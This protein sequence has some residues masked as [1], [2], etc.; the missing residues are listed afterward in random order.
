MKPTTFFQYHFHLKAFLCIALLEFI[1]LPGLIHGQN[2]NHPISGFEDH[3]LGEGTYHYYDDGGPNGNYS[4]NINGSSIHFTPAQGYYIEWKFVQYEF[5]LDPFCGAEQCCD[6]LTSSWLPTCSDLFINQ[7]YCGSFVQPCCSTMALCSGEGIS[8]S[9]TSDASVPKPGWHIIIYVSLKDPY[10]MICGSHQSCADLH[11]IDC[12]GVIGINQT[13]GNPRTSEVFNCWAFGS[14]AGQVDYYLECDNGYY[15]GPERFYLFNLSQNQDL[16][17]SCECITDLFVITIYQCEVYTC[18]KAD[19]VGGEFILHDVPA[20]EHY[21]VAEYDCGGDICGCDLQFNCMDP[22]SGEL[23]CDDAEPIE[24]GNTFYDATFASTG[25]VNN[26]D[27]YCDINS[28]EWTGREKVYEFVASFT[29]QVTITISGL[30]DDLDLFVLEGC[31]AT[32]CVLSSLHFG[33][34]DESVTIDV[35]EGHHYFIVVDGY[36]LAESDYWI[37]V[38]CEGDLDCS[39]DEPLECGDVIFSSNSAADGGINSE[40]DYCGDGTSKWTGRERIYSFYAERNEIITITLSDMEA[41]LDMFL[42]E[43]CNGAVCADRSDG[44]GTSDETIS[45]QVHQG[46][47]YII[48]IDGVDGAT[49]TYSLEVECESLMCKDCGDCF[50]YT[51]FDKGVNSNVACHPKYVDCGVD[52]YPSADHQFQWTVDGN[53]K[54]TKY[55]PTLSLE[56]NKK[57]KVCQVVKYKGTQI[58]KC[59]WDI[60]PTPGCAKPPVA[61]TKLG[62]EWPFYNAVLDA[63]ESTDG[64]RYSWEFGDGT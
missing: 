54:S 12:S 59:C 50:T 60:K 38:T 14:C 28:H 11:T 25:G 4:N 55:S 13:N 33:T 20:G 61:H 31:D 41:N 15:P 46:H 34:V 6:R 44:P 18:Q 2:F 47:T 43:E 8:F 23:G 16:S 10:H 26:E 58:F 40:I 37:S 30:N 45:F 3:T 9:F 29:G 52:H 62:G 7:D 63:S 17:L 48:V 21:L 49:S 36:L 51:I 22:G 53:V 56:N 35:I 57:V 5:E 1:S 19:E 27:D 24:C 64:A 32:S 39:D 42:L